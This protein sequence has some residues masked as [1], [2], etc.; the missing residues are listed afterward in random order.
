M[1]E[2]TKTKPVADVI[3]RELSENLYCLQK[4]FKNFFY[5]A[6]L[7]F[8]FSN[9][10]TI[11]EISWNAGVVSTNFSEYPDNAYEGSYILHVQNSKK[12]QIQLDLI[13]C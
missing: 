8:I 6:I 13:L 2:T 12:C 9:R 1:I 5:L 4:I 11:L 3:R 10:T 7:L